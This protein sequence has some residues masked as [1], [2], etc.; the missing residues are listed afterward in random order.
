[1]S[2][3][4]TLVIL[5]LSSHR[6]YKTKYLTLVDKCF[7]SLYEGFIRSTRNVLLHNSS[8]G[9]FITGDVLHQTSLEGGTIVV[10]CAETLLFMFVVDLKFLGGKQNFVPYMWRLYLPVFLL[11]VWLFALM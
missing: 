8:W 10:L 5:N 9:I 2:G 4:T 7:P 3:G 1:M 11:R 6:F